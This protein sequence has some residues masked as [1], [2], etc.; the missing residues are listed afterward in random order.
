MSYANFKE[1]IWSKYIQHQKEKLLTFK[2]DCDFKFEG[3]AKQGKRVKI[4]GVGRPTIKK[5]VPG[6]EIDGAETPEDSSIF[7]DI[8]QYDYF[9]YGVD[10]IDKAQSK[11]GLMEALAEETTRGLAEAED[12]YLARVAATGAESDGIAASTAI[13][14]GANA[15]KAIDNAFEYL[16]YNG[17]TTKDKVTIYLTPW[18]YL[19][20]QDKLVELKTQNDSLLA[21]GVLGLY[22]SANVKMSNQLHN[23][24]TDDH[25]IVKTSKAI[26]LCDGIDKLEAYRPE[27]KFMDAVK[28]LNTYGAKVVRPKEL[29]VIKAHR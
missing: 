25:I 11:E 23:D 18:F 5:Y 17:V 15:K 29:Y 22:N 13:T 19:L 7:L 9:N 2:P 16:W 3:E 8:D 1:T 26:A 21:K 24:G 28:G 12:A 4:L 14:T 20:F 27:K 6:T 10:D